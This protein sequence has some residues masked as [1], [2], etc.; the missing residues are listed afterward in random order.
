MLDFLGLNIILILVVVLIIF[1][2]LVLLIRK[3]ARQ[4]FLH[5]VEPDDKGKKE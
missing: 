3:R 2:Y 4:N 5:H 1:G